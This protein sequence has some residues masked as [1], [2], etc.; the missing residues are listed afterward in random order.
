MLRECY[1]FCG[2]ICCW[3]VFVCANVSGV[4]CRY[5]V[6]VGVIVCI[7]ISVGVF[8]GVNVYVTVFVGAGVSV[9]IPGCLCGC[10]RLCGRV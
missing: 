7:N 5:N 10:K 3:C 2:C 6:T 1:P 8:F 9:S 4:I